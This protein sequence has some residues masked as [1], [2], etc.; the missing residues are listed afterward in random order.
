M[1][2]MMRALGLLLVLLLTAVCAKPQTNYIEARLRTAQTLQDLVARSNAVV[3]GVV[4]GTN[5][6][7]PPSSDSVGAV[8]EDY[9]VEATNVLRGQ[10]PRRFVV[11]IVRSYQPSAQNHVFENPHFRPL[12]VGGRYVLF[13]GG[14]FEAGR[15]APAPEPW[16][17]RITDKVRPESPWDAAAV[18]FTAQP[19]VDFIAAVE[20]SAK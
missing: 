2:T 1:R 4:L 3:V 10:V 9:A 17:F 8:L 20:Q 19:L 5:G 11:S 12:A 15:W 7:K 16:R 18:L 13:L 14:E 6:T